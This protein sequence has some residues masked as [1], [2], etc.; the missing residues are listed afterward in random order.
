MDQLAFAVAA[1]AAIILLILAVLFAFPAK[2]GRRPQSDAF[3]NPL[4]YRPA[5]GSQWIHQRR[6]DCRG[7]TRGKPPSIEEG[8]LPPSAEQML[9]TSP[10]CW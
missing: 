7:I 8:E 1:A 9:C 6:G 10:A 5:C 2:R 3:L 4:I